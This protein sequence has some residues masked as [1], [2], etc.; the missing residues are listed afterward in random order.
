MTAMVKPMT[1]ALSSKISWD[2]L[3]WKTIERQV[4]RLQVR[5]AK[6]YRE[7]R[8]GK[9]KALQWLLTHSFQLKLWL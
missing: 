9:V 6:A 3:N 7:G 1:G 5:I 4:Y 8:Q 2:S